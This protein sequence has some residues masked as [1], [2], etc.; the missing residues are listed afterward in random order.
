[1][2]C[3]FIGAGS[4]NTAYGY[5]PDS[6]SMDGYYPLASL[7][8]KEKAAIIQ[9]DMRR[10]FIIQRDKLLRKRRKGVQNGYR[11]SISFISVGF[12]HAD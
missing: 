2:D 5:Y 3:L 6:D 9:M 8:K 1:M 11:V 10:R 12:C 4:G 7:G